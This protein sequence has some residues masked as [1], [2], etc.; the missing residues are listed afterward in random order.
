[1]KTRADLASGHRATAQRVK[2]FHVQPNELAWAR[3]FISP[4]ASIWS[5]NAAV[6]ACAISIRHRRALYEKRF[7]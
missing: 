4:R 2:A 5:P 3:V 6:S 7:V 1:V